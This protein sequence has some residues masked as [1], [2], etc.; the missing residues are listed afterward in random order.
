MVKVELHPAVLFHCD[1][2]SEDTWHN[3]TLRTGIDA[4]AHLVGDFE[5]AMRMDQFVKKIQQRCHESNMRCPPLPDFKTA[6][7]IHAKFRCENCGNAVGSMGHGLS[8]I[9][10]DCGRNNYF[11][12]EEAPNT[13]ECQHCHSRFEAEHFMNRGVNDNGDGD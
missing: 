7:S 4:L 2:C 12:P 13:V 10:D 8:F 5:K 11:L 1:F 3:C 6:V 9:C